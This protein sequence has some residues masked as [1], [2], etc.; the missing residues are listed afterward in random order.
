M[1]ESGELPQG[2]SAMGGVVVARRVTVK[3]R[4]RIEQDPTQPNLRQV[5]LMHEEFFDELR[6]A[7]FR[8][9]A[10]ELGENVTTRGIDLLAGRRP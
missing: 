3:H 2:D 7:G 1:T 10:G 5:H 6:V 9:A 8:V 4:S